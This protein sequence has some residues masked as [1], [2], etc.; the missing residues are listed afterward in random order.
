[1]KPVKKNNFFTF[2]CS[3]VPGAV[4]LYFG[5]MKC[6]ISLLLLFA[7]SVAVP[8]AMYGGD[9]FY[10][11]PIV[12]YIYSFFHARNLAKTK[13]DV[14]ETI[15]DKYIWEEFAGDGKVNIPVK[16]VRKWIAIV[17]IVFGVCCIWGIFDYTLFE[18]L[19]VFIDLDKYSFIYGII[20]RVPQVA[21]AVLAILGGA[22]LIAGK[23]EQVNEDGTDNN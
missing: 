5:F 2:L 18:V 20:E 11:I 12:I 19:R 4:E 9:L 1:M 14:F 21:V 16:T 23:K 22:K 3:F 17:L 13:D 7:V 10:V 6:G 8:A 15:E